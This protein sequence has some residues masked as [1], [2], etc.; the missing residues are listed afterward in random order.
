M[1]HI[2]QILENDFLNLGVKGKEKPTDLWDRR[3]YKS[4]YHSENSPQYSSRM[5]SFF[6]HI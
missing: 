2:R 3:I 4:S 5:L 1:K 6:I